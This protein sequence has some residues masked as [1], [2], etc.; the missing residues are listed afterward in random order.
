[1]NLLI[2]GSQPPLKIQVDQNL[3]KIKILIMLWQHNLQVPLQLLGTNDPNH[4]M[5]IKWYL[6]GF[7]SLHSKCTPLVTFS[8][9]ALT[10]LIIPSPT[11]DAK[12]VGFHDWVETTN[13]KPKKKT[14]D[15]SQA[16]NPSSLRLHWR[17]GTN[18]CQV[19]VE[20]TFQVQD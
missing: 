16:W 14:A 12:Q 7:F 5:V 10:S 2:K 3:F 13:E 8:G 18:E 15:Q 4:S 11:L 6:Q 19:H 20:K 17:Q 1:M 9:A